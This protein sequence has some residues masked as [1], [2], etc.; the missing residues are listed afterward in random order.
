LIQNL[1]VIFEKYLFEKTGGL[2]V[3]GRWPDWQMVV[4][5]WPTKASP[6]PKALVGASGW[7]VEGATSK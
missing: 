1:S 7:L 4:G 2:M 6:T 5:S 3:I